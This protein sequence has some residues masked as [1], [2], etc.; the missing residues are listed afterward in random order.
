MGVLQ[1]TQGKFPRR[2]YEPSE[3]YDRAG[4]AFHRSSG[5]SLE[6]SGQFGP[7]PHAPGNVII[8]NGFP[9]GLHPSAYSQFLPQ[10]GFP[11]HQMSQRQASRSPSSEP[12]ARSPSRGRRSRSQTPIPTAQDAKSTFKN[13]QQGAWPV[14]AVPGGFFVPNIPKE[15]HIHVNESRDTGR[16]SSSTSNP[17]TRE[18]SRLTIRTS[19]SKSSSGR[20]ISPSPAP[21]RRCASP[22]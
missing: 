20:N 1:A 3:I 10:P 18:P 5:S 17:P 7:T 19:R 12:T 22:R 2:E 6:Q 13:L 14:Q 11:G 9:F 21:Y 8:N 16:A 4:P 15:R